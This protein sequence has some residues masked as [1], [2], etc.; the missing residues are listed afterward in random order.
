MADPRLLPSEHGP[1]QCLRSSLT[2]AEVQDIETE[3]IICVT[4]SRTDSY[5]TAW[6]GQ[7]SGIRKYDLSDE[8][9]WRLLKPLPDEQVYPTAPPGLDID[10]HKDTDGHYV[11]RA[12]LVGFEDAE[13]AKILPMILLEGA[14]IRVVNDRPWSVWSVWSLAIDRPTIESSLSKRPNHRGYG[15]S[16]GRDHG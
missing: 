3:E 6:F 8:D 2:V 4:C 10:D 13:M 15:R 9:L 11:K 14:K 12:N 1:Y 16:V 5:G 7:I